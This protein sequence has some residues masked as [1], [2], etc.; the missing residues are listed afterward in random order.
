MFLLRGSVAAL[1][2]QVAACDLVPHLKE[3]LLD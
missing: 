1:M 3:Q 2:S